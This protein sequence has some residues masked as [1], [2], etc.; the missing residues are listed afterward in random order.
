ME[1]AAAVIL[2]V[3]SS[4]FAL[5]SSRR[6]GGDALAH[7]VDG[8]AKPAELL[9]PPA[10]TDLGI[11]R[12]DRPGLSGIERTEAI[13]DD[14][15]GTGL[16]AVPERVLDDLRQL[17]RRHRLI[18][19]DVPVHREDAAEACCAAKRSTARPATSDPD[20]QR[21]LERRR[22][23][24]RLGKRVVTAAVRERLAA[25]EAGDDLETLVE[26]FGT[27]AVV[28]ILAE[29]GELF[30]RQRPQ[31]C[32]EDDAPVRELVERRDLAC[33]LPGASAGQNAGHDAE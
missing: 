12:D 15:E 8:P 9:D 19:A 30:L 21:A 28:G 25:P 3:V 14:V 17:R 33:N 27:E 11:G 6:A 1:N 26:P 22:P 18:E 2:T 20:R 24:D 7:L 10:Q 16:S 13:H 23:E 4:H 31:D 29:G 32:T 5:A